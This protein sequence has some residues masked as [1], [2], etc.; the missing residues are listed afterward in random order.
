MPNDT[1][2]VFAQAPPDE[3]WVVSDRQPDDLRGPA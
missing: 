3:L 2:R 1:T